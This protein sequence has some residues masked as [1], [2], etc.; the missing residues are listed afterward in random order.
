MKAYMTVTFI[1]RFLTSALDVVRVQ[2]RASAVFPRPPSRANGALQMRSHVGLKSGQE[3]SKKRKNC[4]PCLESNCYFSVILYDVRDLITSPSTFIS[5]KNY[6]QQVEE[7]FNTQIFMQREVA[8]FVVA[9]NVV[10][11]F[12]DR[13]MLV[14]FG[15]LT[16]TD[17]PAGSMS[18]AIFDERLMDVQ[19]VKLAMSST[20]VFACYTNPLT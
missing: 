19:S 10:D 11:T 18:P 16:Q 3:A 4:C 13:L 20:A 17:V 7:F 5:V 9:T 14:V 1:I 15:C 12:S 2:L 8:D 6:V